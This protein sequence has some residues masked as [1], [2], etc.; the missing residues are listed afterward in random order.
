[1]EEYTKVL[2]Q[3]LKD[4]RDYTKAMFKIIGTIWRGV[5]NNRFTLE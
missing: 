4:K 5:N 3:N 2:K 1:M